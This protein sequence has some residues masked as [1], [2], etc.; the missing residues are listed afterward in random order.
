MNEVKPSGMT[1]NEKTRSWNAI[2]GGLVQHG[3]FSYAALW[4]RGQSKIVASIVGLLILGG[5]AATAYAHNAKPGDALFPIEI[6]K[7]KA[8]ILFAGDEKKKEEL[9]IKFA[10]KRL[11]EVRELAAL[12]PAA[13]A[14]TTTV[15]ASTTPATTT[16]VLSK[17]DAKKIARTERAITIALAQLTETKLK[18]IANGQADAAMLIDDII[19][20]LKGVGDGSVTITR[21]AS[22]GN[23]GRVSLRA[24]LTASSSASSTVTSSV[25]IEEKK[26]GS[27]IEIKNSFIKTKV[28]INGENKQDDDDKDD[29]KG[30]DRDDDEDEDEDDDKDDNRGHGNGGKKV[31]VCHKSGIAPMTL[32]ISSSAARAHLAHGDSLGVCTGVN[33][34]D[35]TAPVLANISAV[36]TQSSVVIAWSTNEAADARVW[37]STSSPTQTTGAV[38]ASRTTLGT[39]HSLSASALTPSTTYFYV[40]VSTDASGNRATSSQFS[41]A[42]PATPATIDNVAPSITGIESSVGTTNATLSWSTNESAKTRLWLSTSTAIDTSLVATFEESAFA[43]NHSVVRSSLLPGTTY[44]YVLSAVDA[45]GN[46]STSSQRSFTTSAPADTTAPV[47]SNV[48]SVTTAS[49][50]TV[51]WNTNEA[52]TGTLYFGTVTPV[53]FGGSKLQL[54]TLATSHN[55]LLSGLSASTTYHLIIVAKDSA[56]NTATSSPSSFI[57][58]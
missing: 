14:S 2:E 47:I 24:T 4:K 10:E 8:Q 1:P 26:N 40:V 21:V 37:I 52:S 33:V 39:A 28:T 35:A 5:G 42:T 45:V 23:G 6:A 57:I 32:R 3:Q 17:N 56:G 12:I 11:R 25:R 53:D 9:H 29:R 46:R 55:A 43:T 16:P 41:F 54:G 50:A 48:G 30:K 7:E 38:S 31:S 27:K 22:N 49:T 58:N 18:L 19:Q 36:P 51:T 15:I 44:H 34:P 20:E 13:T